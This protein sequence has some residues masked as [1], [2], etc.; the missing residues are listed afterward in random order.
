LSG[1][2]ARVL[3]SSFI[4]G[5]GHRAVVFLQGCDFSCLYCHNPE[6]QRLCTNCGACVPVCPAGALSLE[7]GRV[8]WKESACARCDSCIRACPNY[9]SPRVKAYEASGL[10]EGLLALLPFIDGVTF[11]GGECSLQAG[12]IL[13]LAAILRAGAADRGQALS[14]IADTNGATEEAAF[15][16]FLAGM[17]GFIFDLK[18]PSEESHLALTGRP[19]SPVLANMGKAA[20]A[21][22]LV[23]VRTVLVEGYNDS[24]AE[25]GAAADI[26]AGMLARGTAWPSYR[27]IPYRPQGVRGEFAGRRPYPMD[28]FDEIVGTMRKRFG[29]RVVTPVF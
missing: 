24:A 1:L 2:V 27:L 18:A 28:K 15:E 22:K 8:A 10:A 3:E 20:A 16:A 6:T 7:A 17:D 4:D 11:S 5:P 29:S 13:E 21:G 26:F 12:F 14:L 25:V 19:L 23:E 9:S